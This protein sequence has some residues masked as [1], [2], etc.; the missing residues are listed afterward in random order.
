MIEYIG[1]AGVYIFG[2]YVY[3]RAN[4]KCERP[5]IL[6]FHGVSDSF[7]LSITRNSI[8]GFARIMD[9]LSL[10]G[11]TG[12]DLS[13]INEPDH[14]ALT[15]DD[16]FQDFYDNAYP[17]LDDYEFEAT[18]FLVSDYIG[19][20]SDWDYQSK[21]HM[22]RE[23]IK[24]LSDAG[25]EFGSHGKT[26]VD[27]RALDDDHLHEELEGS[28]KAIEDLLGKPVKYFSYPFGRFDNRVIEMVK[29][30][31]YEKAVS[32]CTGADQF[33]LPRHAVYL[34]DTPYSIDRKLVK[35]SWPDICKDYMNNKLAG[36]TIALKKIIPAKEG[37]DDEKSI[38][39]A[40]V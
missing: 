17:I 31:G 7:E 16:G 8:K 24:E 4:L 28:K 5:P 22:S 34:Y 9:Y 20:R 25:I 1:G 26:H 11:K 38:N 2:W 13:G 29:Q 30:A 15:F 37:E 36:G 6:A 12:C 14:V 40:S 23:M 27:L 39:K 33:S 19:K 32:L 21:K 3:W 35:Q 18:V 10:S